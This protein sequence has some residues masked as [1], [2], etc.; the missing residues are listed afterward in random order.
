VLLDALAADKVGDGMTRPLASYLAPYIADGD[1]LPDTVTVNAAD[2]LEAVGELRRMQGALA[3]TDPWERVEA[4]GE[5]IFFRCRHCGNQ[6]PMNISNPL[7]QHEAD[8][9]WI[10]AVSATLVARA[11]ALAPADG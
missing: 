7:K 5:F 6:Y 9:V 10:L 8:C 3:K 2:L 1:P 11:A 4:A